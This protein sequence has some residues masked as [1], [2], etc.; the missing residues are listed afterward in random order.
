MVMSVPMKSMSYQ[1]TMLW[2]RNGIIVLHGT[3]LQL[4]P[5]HET[6]AVQ[7]PLWSRVAKCYSELCSSNTKHSR[8]LQDQY[9]LWTFC[10][11]QS[12]HKT[13]HKVLRRCLGTFSPGS[14]IPCPW[15]WA[16]YM[17]PPRTKARKL[18]NSIATT[19]R[20]AFRPA[21]LLC[22]GALGGT[23]RCVTSYFSSHCSKR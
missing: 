21:F 17:S 13:S 7:F 19:R 18:S 8:S 3:F 12:T 6:E 20:L 2:I 10:F 16:R 4:A 1:H 15:N 14:T 11:V 5:E 9:T 22:L 23:R